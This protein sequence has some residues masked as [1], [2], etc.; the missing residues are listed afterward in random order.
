MTSPIARI[1]CGKDLLTDAQQAIADTK[2]N[3]GRPRRSAVRP[4]ALG[5]RHTTRVSRSPC[6]GQQ[7]QQE[8]LCVDPACPAPW[9]DDDRLFPTGLIRAP[10]S[11]RECGADDPSGPG[12]AVK[13]A[14]D[15]PGIVLFEFITSTTGESWLF[16]RAPDDGSDFANLGST[17]RNIA[18]DLVSNLKVGAGP[19]TAATYLTVR[20]G[21]RRPVPG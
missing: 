8:R 20:I 6:R 18:K 19:E 16:K 2:I 21:W 10:P 15:K 14:A 4:T 17:T 12:E 3:H 5:H 13:I 1:C 11:D 9:R 7:D